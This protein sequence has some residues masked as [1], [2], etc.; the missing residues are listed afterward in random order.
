M[1]TNTRGIGTVQSPYT[2]KTVDTA[3][4]HL[5]RIL[6]SEGAHSLFGQTYWRIRVMQVGA[7]QGLMHAQRVRL[8]RLLDLL[9]NAASTSLHHSLP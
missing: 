4:A 5:E 8:Q 2:A 1:K 7:T 3:I 9:A 6:S